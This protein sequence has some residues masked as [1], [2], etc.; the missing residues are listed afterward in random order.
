[1]NVPLDDPSFFCTSPDP[2]P[3]SSVVADSIVQECAAGKTITL[4]R[5]QMVAVALESEWNTDVGS[6]WTDLS[7]ENSNVL[8]DV[9][10]P[11]SVQAAANSSLR[12]EVAVYWADKPGETTI[13]AVVRWC[14]E[15]VMICDRGAR[16]WVTID[17][18]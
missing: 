7:V 18:K 4:S 11:I 17:V 8:R 1:M 6:Q 12:F 10:T 16:W 2:S 3:P 14:N 5:G 9:N 13:S 15:N